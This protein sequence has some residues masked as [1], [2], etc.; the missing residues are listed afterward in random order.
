MQIIDKMTRNDIE[1]NSINTP[2]MLYKE[3]EILSVLDVIHEIISKNPITFLYSIKACSDENILQII[4]NY[5]DGFS[6]SSV[7]ESMFVSELF[8]S[9]KLIHY[10]S[11]LIKDGEINKILKACS[12][13]TFNSLTQWK[14]YKDMAIQSNVSPGLRVNPNTSF[15]ENDRYNPSGEYSKLGVSTSTLAELIKRDISQFSGLEGIHFHNNCDS[16][17]FTQ[18]LR[19]VQQLD[20]AI[21]PLLREVRWINLGGGYYF[22]KENDYSPLFGAI[23][24]LKNKY[25]LEVII[26]PGAALVQDAGRIVSEVI[27]MFEADGKTIA[28]LDTSINHLPEVIEFG[29]DPEIEGSLENGE[30]EY[31]LAGASCLAGDK[32]GTYRFESHLNIGDRVIIINT[33]AYSIVK[34]HMFNGIDLPDIYCVRQ[35]GDI[36]LLRQHGYIDFLNRNGAMI[37]E[38]I[39]KRA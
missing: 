21:P 38:S 5:V 33:G 9:Q 16:S 1:L 34:M 10:V 2:A 26:E 32:F 27:D 23:E 31:I 24:L 19:T 3:S 13:I 36:D 15:V 14:R 12:S 11:P 29:Y 8:P 18:L 6:C 39:R 37:S 17:D 20:S 25:D 7:F 30:Y 22:D 35:N 28:I 4:N